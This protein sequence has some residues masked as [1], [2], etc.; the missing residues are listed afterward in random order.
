[1]EITVEILGR[2]LCKDKKRRPTKIKIEI[3]KTEKNEIK[4]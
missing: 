3:T 4:G 1:M 2:E